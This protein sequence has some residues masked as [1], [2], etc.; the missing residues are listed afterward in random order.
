MFSRKVVRLALFSASLTLVASMA[1][2][3]PSAPGNV[4]VPPV[5]TSSSGSTII[6]SKPSSYSTVA[7]YNVYKNGSLLGNTTK[8]FYMPTGLSA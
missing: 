3:A 1:Q 8:L 2:A 5:A 4:M 7:S 6:W